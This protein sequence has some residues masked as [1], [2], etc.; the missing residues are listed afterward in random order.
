MKQHLAT[1]EPV[2][3]VIIEE[4]DDGTG[5][6]RVPI[7]IE[8]PRIDLS[9]TASPTNAISAITEQELRDMDGNFGKANKPIPVGFGDHFPEASGGPGA[10]FILTTS[11]GDL[12]GRLALFADVDI[13]EPLAFSDVVRGVWRGFSFEN[14]LNL[15][16]ATH[17]FE[18]WALTGGVFTNRPATEVHFSRKAATEYLYT[19][20]T[21]VG[22]G[23]V[24]I[25]RPVRANKKGLDMSNGET[26]VELAAL[27]A[28]NTE[29][30]T[31]I[32]S[33]RET[34]TE[35]GEA[36]AAARRELTTEQA[37]HAGTKAR[38]RALSGDLDHANATNET[39][40]DR[41]DN[42]ER[43]LSDAKVANV[44]VEVRALVEAGVDK[45]IPPAVFEGY[46]DDV[47]T[48][49]SERYGGVDRLKRFIDS[50]PKR[51]KGSA[52]TSGKSTETIPDGAHNLS[53]EQ[54]ANL[55]RRGLDP[56]LADVTTADGLRAVR[57]RESAE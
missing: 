5:V 25:A 24:S 33:L 28:A 54:V 14:A 46:A 39:L 9:K 36:G 22:V 34:N 49:L 31:T 50:Y 11:L 26:A 18:G 4:R 48:W 3:L 35:V 29:Q 8:T 51:R 47:A 2:D 15:A 10:A 19:A 23:T 43:E 21:V 12:G 17:E 13:V 37:D 7:G 55:K 6:V 20:N 30:E 38:V 45:G 41:V 42:L 52:T 16:T 32:R 1:L 40:R 53:D 56:A 44:D 57:E 27:K